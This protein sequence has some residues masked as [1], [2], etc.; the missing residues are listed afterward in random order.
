MSK[1][2]LPMRKIK[3]VLRMK[4]SCGISERRIATSCH[5]SRSTVADCIGRAV[6][7]GL[8]WPLPDNMDDTRL[9]ALLYPHQLHHQPN[10]PCLTGHKSIRR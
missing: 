8:S 6:A 9:D 2:K 10:V 5:I 7:A 1:R 4:W 3:E